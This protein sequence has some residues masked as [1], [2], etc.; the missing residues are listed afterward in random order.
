MMKILKYILIFVFITGVGLGG[1]TYLDTV[2]SGGAENVNDTQQDIPERKDTELFILRELMQQA[3]KRRNERLQK[4]RKPDVDWEKHYGV[5]KPSPGTYPVTIYENDEVPLPAS[6]DIEDVRWFDNETLILVQDIPSISWRDGREDNAFPVI[7]VRLADLTIKKIGRALRVGVCFDARSKKI[8]YVADATY[9]GVEEGKL[10]KRLSVTFMHGKFPKSVHRRKV[11]TSNYPATDFTVNQFD[12]TLYVRENEKTFGWPEG[13]V[14]LREGD[15]FFGAKPPEQVRTIE[16]GTRIITQKPTVYV[17]V[18]PEGERR[19]FTL[20]DAP[21]RSY[22]KYDSAN[23]EYWLP[24]TFSETGEMVI[25]RFDSDTFQQVSKKKYKAGPWPRNGLIFAAKNGY[26]IYKPTLKEK[27][28]L[29][30]LTHDGQIIEVMRDY[31]YK[32]NLSI[33]PNGCR[34]AFFHQDKHSNRP[35]AP[36]KIAVVEL[37]EG[38]L[39]KRSKSK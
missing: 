27:N 7:I 10:K 17:Y 21:Y 14:P 28:Y 11:V 12:C 24:Y 13:T 1:W 19:E 16:N 34:A 18:S 39:N 32:G 15:G 2:N 37:C 9:G 5:I 30:L 36:K 29:Y 3:E 31:G 26:L 35:Q 4:N 8:S 23:D 38:E 6:G 22:L 25:A 20:V 33:S